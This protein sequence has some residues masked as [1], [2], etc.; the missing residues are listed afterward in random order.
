MFLNNNRLEKINSG[1]FKGKTV[2]EEVDLSYNDIWKVA[3]KGKHFFTFITC[4]IQ[5]LE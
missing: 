5:E 2:L 4:K 3:V 1:L